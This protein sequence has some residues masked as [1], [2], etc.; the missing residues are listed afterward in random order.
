MFGAYVRVIEGFGFLGGK[1]ENFFDAR[2]IR[3]VADHF[4]IGTGT[5]LL[6]DLHA[7][8]FQVETQ[9]LKNIDGDALAELDEAEQQMLG[10]HKIVVEPI[11]LFAGKSENLLSARGKIIHRFVT[12]T[13]KCN[14]LSS[15]SNP[16]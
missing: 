14:Y 5:H 15:L 8:R 1:S 7:N 2:R 11:G 13:S 9:L 16:A 12:H 6:L 3:N 4:L 10:P